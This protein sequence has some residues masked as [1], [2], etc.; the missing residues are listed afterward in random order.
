[1]KCAFTHRSVPYPT[2]YGFGGTNIIG[3]TAHNCDT[4]Y[5]NMTCVVGKIQEL[6]EQI[7]ELRST[8]SRIDP[9]GYSRSDRE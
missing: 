1:M 9:S 6:E 3:C 7:N 5:D 8:T 4:L 2:S